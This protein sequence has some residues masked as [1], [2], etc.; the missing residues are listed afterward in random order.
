MMQVCKTETDGVEAL[1]LYGIAVLEESLESNQNPS[2]LISCIARILAK[3][4]LTVG[5]N[6]VLY[7][8]A[9]CIEKSPLVYL[10]ELLSLSECLILAEI[11]IKM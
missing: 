2:E 7:L 5:Q 10:E 9:G 11:L 8:L 6:C 1:I 3:N 4:K